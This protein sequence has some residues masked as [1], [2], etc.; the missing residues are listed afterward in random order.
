LFDGK[1]E[2]IEYIFEPG[3]IHADGNPISFYLV[4]PI[5]TASSGTM[6]EWGK[7]YG[8]RAADFKARGYGDLAKKYSDLAFNILKVE[9]VANG[10]TIAMLEIGK[11]VEKESAP[12]MSNLVEAFEWFQKSA[13][14]GNAEAKA[15]LDR[16]G[17]KDVVHLA[18]EMQQNSHGP[19]PKQELK[20]AAQY[21]LGSPWITKNRSEATRLFKKNLEEC[22]KSTFRGDAESQYYLGLMYSEGLGVSKDIF[23]GK[24]YLQA[25]AEGSS[26]VQRFAQDYLDHP[27]APTS[28]GGGALAQSSDPSLE[29]YGIHLVS[30]PGGSFQMGSPA[31]E[32]NRNNDE[33]QHEV[34]LSPFEMM[35]SAVTQKTYALVM[36]RNP[37]HFQSPNDCHESDGSSDFEELHVD[38]SVVKVC[39]NH[40]VEKVSW[41]DSHDF[42]SKLNQLLANSGYHFKLPTEA[43]YEYAFRGGTT[44]AYVS[45]DFASS[46][47]DYVWYSDNSGHHSHGVRTKRAND[48]GIYR[49]SVWEW[50][51]DL[52]R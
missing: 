18:Q 28:T 26:A 36:G 20:L 30:L 1:L 14:A 12:G 16:P 3:K 24:I 17:F 11:K 38:G 45:D 43:Q 10:D 13:Q 9:A 5:T 32:L 33:R 52:V 41:T 4:R 6:G 46:L 29:H 44:T 7:V 25:A 47:G 8:D 15:L 23:V 34:I 48:Y 39:A 27:A 51:E 37:S 2:G 40:P 50:S 21:A 31:G 42:V 49:S 22:V 35:D 19:A